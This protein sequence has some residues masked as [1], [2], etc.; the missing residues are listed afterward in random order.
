MT[1]VS[2]VSRKHTR[3]PHQM[4]PQEA[5]ALQEATVLQGQLS[6]VLVILD[7]LPIQGEPRPSTIVLHV[8]QENIVQVLAENLC[9]YSNKY[10]FLTNEFPISLRY[11]LHQLTN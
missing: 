5:L 4:A 11:Y 8:H 9:N 2:T 1:Q 7:F 10:P 3:L 6:P